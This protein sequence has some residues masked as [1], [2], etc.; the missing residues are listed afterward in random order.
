MCNAEAGRKSKTSECCELFCA[1][2]R[3]AYDDEAL[4]FFLYCRRWAQAALSDATKR[5]ERVT[6]SSSSVEA[7]G[8]GGVEDA[9]V[10][11][12]SSP[13]I[14]L[15][16]MS[17]DIKQALT[18]VRLIFV[19]GEAEGA[20]GTSSSSFLHATVRAMIDDAFNTD[21]A[22]AKGATTT[23]KQSL[24]TG[25]E[26]VRMDVYR[27]LKMLLSVFVDTTPPANAT[28]AKTTTTRNATPKTSTS[29]RGLEA[30]MNAVALDNDAVKSSSQREEQDAPPPPDRSAEIA[31]YELAVRAALAD[32]ASKYAAA[33]FPAKV[34]RA[35]ISDAEIELNAA[36]QDLLTRVID[37]ASLDGDETADIVNEA[38]AACKA[39][40]RARASLL[41]GAGTPGSESPAMGS[42]TRDIARALLATP[43]MRQTI[44]P[45]LKNAV[46]ALKSS[47]STDA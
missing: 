2:V 11:S 28:P 14:N 34:P 41:S 36:A 30:A 12:S 45:L 35:T 16:E 40:A 26:P 6:S 21:W 1:F 31:R 27:L 20:G 44:E 15:C 47:S 17:L 46:E 18:I 24:I 13:G 3:G 9:N 19:G 7:R 10:S 8:A 4:L 5:G 25:A 39:Y 29:T 33:V 32:A 42:S 23:P 38:P 37:N 22:T 43:K